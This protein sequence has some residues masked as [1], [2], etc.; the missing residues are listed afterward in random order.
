M[1]KSPPSQTKAIKTDAGK[2]SC[3]ICRVVDMEGIASDV[4][5]PWANRISANKS[6]CAN[7]P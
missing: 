6:C 1:S 4:V 2:G 7:R 5:H 3:G